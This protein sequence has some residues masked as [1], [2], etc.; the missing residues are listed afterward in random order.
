MSVHW[1]SG[2][3]ENRVGKRWRCCF[4]AAAADGRHLGRRD[5]GHNARFLDSGS[6]QRTG[7]GREPEGASHLS[8]EARKKS[9][10]LL[11]FRVVDVELYLNVS[12]PG[13]GPWNRAHFLCGKQ[14]TCLRS[15]KIIKN[16]ERKTKTHNEKIC[17][18][19]LALIPVLQSASVKLHFQATPENVNTERKGV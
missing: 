4:R 10:L 14:R 9:S 5:D 7:Q 3:V 16:E 2:E 18:R 8:R 13:V 19:D 17:T 1:T 15:K 6:G 12:D 11:R